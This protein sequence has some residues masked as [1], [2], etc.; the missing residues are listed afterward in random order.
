MSDEEPEKF[1]MPRLPGGKIDLGMREQILSRWLEGAN[2]KTI[3]EEFKVSAGAIRNII[4]SEERTTAVKNN[5]L[6]F[7]SPERIRVL[8]KAFVVAESMI[9]RCNDEFRFKTL[10]DALNVLIHT[11]RIEEGLTG[12]SAAGGTKLEMTFKM[13]EGTKTIEGESFPELAEGDVVVEDNP[14]S[15]AEEALPSKPEDDYT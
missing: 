2:K 12:A 7:G 8:N 14:V 3:A 9:E 6:D 10:V 15:E 13:E 4:N 5:K 1:E 11:R